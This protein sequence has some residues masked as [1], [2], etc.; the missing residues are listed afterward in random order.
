MNQILSKGLHN[1]DDESM[2]YTMRLLD[3][4]EQVN[5]FLMHFTVTTADFE[6]EQS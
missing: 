6:V 5:R 2:T 1:S 4:L 3:K